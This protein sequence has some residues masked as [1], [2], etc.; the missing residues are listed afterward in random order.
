MTDA[1]SSA[2]AARPASSPTASASA[3]AWP[4]PYQSQAARLPFCT[5]ARCCERRP[6]SRRART[7]LPPPPQPARQGS[8]L[9][10][11]A[12]EPTARATRPNQCARPALKIRNLRGEV[13]AERPFPDPLHPGGQPGLGNHP[14]AQWDPGCSTDEQEDRSNGAPQNVPTIAAGGLRS[15]PSNFGS[16]LTP[17]I[18][19]RSR[20]DAIVVTWRCQPWTEPRWVRMPLWS[21]G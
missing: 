20:T 13:V 6:P 10:V 2:P 4:V 3:L 12:V 21:T 19:T 14:S 11:E 17:A 7:A 9:V 5:K 18:H 15:A 16:S 1:A 8:L